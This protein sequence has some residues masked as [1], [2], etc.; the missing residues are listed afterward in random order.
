MEEQ[1]GTSRRSLILAGTALVVAS[2]LFGA[3]FFYFDGAGLVSGLIADLGARPP[4][5]QPAS[6]STTATVL[7]LPEGMPERF[8]LQLWQE[9]VE[10]QETIERL[11]SGEF[12]SMSITRVQTGSADATLSVTVK[13]KQ[14]HPLSGVLLLRRF[15]ADWYVA[16]VSAVVDGGFQGLPRGATDIADVDIPLLNTVL[17]QQGSS[18]PVF[19]EYVAGTVHRINFEK[20]TKG[21]GTVTI[22]VSMN[23]DHGTGLAQIV[24]IRNDSGKNSQWFL[25]RFKKTGDYVK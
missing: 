2:I 24:A 22:D 21:P 25:A 4:A 23:E 17:A 8:A 7:T 12:T 9:Q 14:G 20:F 16:G 19:D 1:Q 10:S 6:A 11:V 3:A 5:P 15:G 13:S 18:Q